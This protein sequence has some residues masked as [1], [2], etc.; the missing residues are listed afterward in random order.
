MVKSKFSSRSR[1]R[2]CVIGGFHQNIDDRVFTFALPLSHIADTRCR[3]A[4][5]ITYRLS[6]PIFG[7]FTG[8]LFYLLRKFVRLIMNNSYEFTIDAGTLPVLNTYLHRKYDATNRECRK[9][10]TTQRLCKQ[11]LY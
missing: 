9:S 3:Q 7:S 1:C 2:Y 10:I 6:K 11:H 4:S 8:C 5:R